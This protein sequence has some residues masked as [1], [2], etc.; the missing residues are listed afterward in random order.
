M[1]M[2][3]GNNCKFYL[4]D[5]KGNLNRDIVCVKLIIVKLLVLPNSSID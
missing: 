1:Y 4:T 3:S 2:I 5:I